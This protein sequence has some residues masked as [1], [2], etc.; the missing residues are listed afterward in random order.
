MVHNSTNINRTKYRSSPQITEY[1]KDNDIYQVMP[2]K[3]L[4]LTWN[5]HKNV[6]A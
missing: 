5:R 3:I 4:V 6:E 2:T 1:K